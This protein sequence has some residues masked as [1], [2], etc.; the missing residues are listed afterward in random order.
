MVT[1]QTT[2]EG[3]FQGSSRSLNLRLAHVMFQPAGSNCAASA[4]V[5]LGVMFGAHHP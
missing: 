4:F 2:N 1:F 5:T 3:R